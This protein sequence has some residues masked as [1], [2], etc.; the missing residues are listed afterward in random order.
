MCTIY[1]KVHAFFFL[2]EILFLFNKILFQNLY[3]SLLNVVCHLVCLMSV[4]NPNNVT[5]KLTA[6]RHKE[7]L[8][9]FWSITKIRFKIRLI[10]YMDFTII[11]WLIK[12][13]LTLCFKLIL[14]YI[15]ILQHAKCLKW[16]TKWGYIRYGA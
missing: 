7:W 5:S 14:C 12:M 16:D 1:G 6:N 10:I 13:K 8:S 3:V 15:Y 2:L 11:M 4:S 9:E